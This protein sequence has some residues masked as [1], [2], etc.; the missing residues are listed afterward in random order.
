M[1]I[2]LNELRDARTI[3][4][5]YHKRHQDA[6]GRSTLFWASITISQGTDNVARR[7]ARGHFDLT[8]KYRGRF[9]YHGTRRWV[10]SKRIISAIRS[11]LDDEIASADVGYFK[12][13]SET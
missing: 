10:T 7:E 2:T 4:D 13:E 9:V 1:K 11:F 8:C 5:V 6:N 3:S 12:V